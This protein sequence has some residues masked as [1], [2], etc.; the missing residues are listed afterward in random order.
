MRHKTVGFG[1]GFRDFCLD[2]Y[3]FNSTGRLVWAAFTTY[4][5]L[6]CRR[7]WPRIFLR[8]NPPTKFGFEVFWALAGTRA[9]AS[10]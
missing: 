2:E 3:K 7:Y 10:Q 5:R 9:A 6:S 4:H 8:L 1:D